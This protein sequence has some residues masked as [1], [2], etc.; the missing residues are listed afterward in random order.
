MNSLVDT[1]FD[2]RSDTPSGKDP[3]IYSP[4]LR[5][6][7]QILWSK[8]LPNGIKFDLIENHETSYLYHASQLGT[9][10]LSSDTATHTFSKWKSMSHIIE[11]IPSCEI[12]E[13]RH[14][15]YTIGSMLIFP[16]NRI[17]GKST[18][19]GSRGFHPQIKDRIDLTLECIRRYYLSESSPLSEVLSRYRNFFELF[20]NFKNYVDFFLL[21]DLVEEIFEKI[22]F[23][24]PFNNYH[25]SPVP[26]NIEDYLIYKSNTINFIKN[27]NLRISSY[28]EYSSNTSQRFN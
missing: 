9:F 3:D 26:R 17:D 27:R 23:L 25:G 18:I 8:P 14:M 16:S 7:H 10:Y 11:K 1:T 6:Y 19:N 24:L 21:N 22:K 13:F 12:E 5:R 4:T 20:G 2:F 28:L 15:S